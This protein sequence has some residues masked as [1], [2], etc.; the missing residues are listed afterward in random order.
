MP[1]DGYIKQYDN[2]PLTATYCMYGATTQQ[3]L[4]LD[5]V[6]QA[7]AAALSVTFIAAINLQFVLRNIRR[8]CLCQP[9]S[10]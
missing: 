4:T 9:W 10:G 1:P 3:T 2:N 5:E 6:V 8:P 7:A